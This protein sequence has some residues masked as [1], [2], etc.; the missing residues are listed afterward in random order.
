MKSFEFTPSEA[1][2]FEE[3][4]IDPMLLTVAHKDEF[5]ATPSKPQERS[6]IVVTELTPSNSDTESEHEYNPLVYRTPAI[7]KSCDESS[8]LRKPTNY[9]ISEFE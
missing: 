8:I 2:I 6:R 7:S 4:P 1:K 3:D 5:C 9:S